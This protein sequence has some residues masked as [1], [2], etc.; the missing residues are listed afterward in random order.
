MSIP[1]DKI[2]AHVIHKELGVFSESLGIEEKI[3]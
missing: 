2:D 3:P 1:Y